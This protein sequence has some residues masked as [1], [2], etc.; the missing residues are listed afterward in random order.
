MVALPGVTIAGS[1]TSVFSTVREAFTASDGGSNDVFAAPMR[2]ASSGS[3]CSLL[4]ALHRRHL[5][6]A[7][8]ARRARRPSI[9]GR[10]RMSCADSP[11]ATAASSSARPSA[12]AFSARSSGFL[13]RFCMTTAAI[14]SGTYAAR[15]TLLSGGGAS[16]IC[17]TSSAT[18]WSPSNGVRPASIW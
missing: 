14:G 4:G 13:E 2:A 3:S 12:R 1:G 18:A 11:L 10:A 6:G 9:A 5:H 15:G 16:W 7:R 17:C 8:R